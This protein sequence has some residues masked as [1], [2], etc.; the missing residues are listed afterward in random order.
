MAFIRSSITRKFLSSYSFKKS[1][2]ASKVFSLARACS[3]LPSS[4]TKIFYAR[5]VLSIIDVA[6]S[7]EFLMRFFSFLNQF[8]ILLYYI[9]SEGHKMVPIVYSFNLSNVS[10]LYSFQFERICYQISLI[11]VSS[12]CI[13]FRFFLNFYA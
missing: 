2:L 11:W 3:I 10:M 4:L 12:L 9:L 8:Q 6:F 1:I 7:A 5:S 13:F